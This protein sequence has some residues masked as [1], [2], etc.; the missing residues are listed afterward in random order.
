VKTRQGLIRVGQTAKLYAK[1]FLTDA[2]LLDNPEVHY[3]ARFGKDAGLPVHIISGA[4]PLEKETLQ[5]VVLEWVSENYL[6]VS[7]ALVLIIVLL[8]VLRKR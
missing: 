5:D 3:T 7:A 4:L 8:I 6:L 2:D 1:V